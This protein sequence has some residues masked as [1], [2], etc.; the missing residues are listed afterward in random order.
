MDVLDEQ[1]D[2]ARDHLRSEQVNDFLAPGRRHIVSNLVSP[3]LLAETLRGAYPNLP[4][5]VIVPDVSAI[6]GQLS[7]LGLLDP[8]PISSEEAM[9]SLFPAVE[10]A[11]KRIMAS[12]GGPDDTHHLRMNL[13][14]DNPAFQS[15]LEA[16]VGQKCKYHHSL[17]DQSPSLWSPVNSILFMD[18]R[19]IPGD[20]GKSITDAS[21]FLY[22]IELAKK[23]PTMPIVLFS[24]TQQRALQDTVIEAGETD[25]LHNII[26]R[27]S[28]P[29]LSA[30]GGLNARS[31]MKSLKDLADAAVEAVMMNE[32]SR[33]MSSVKEVTLFAPLYSRRWLEVLLSPAEKPRRIASVPVPEVCQDMELIRE[34][35]MRWA[36]HPQMAEG[37]GADVTDKRAGWVWALAVIR[38]WLA[39]GDPKELVKFVGRL[40]AGLLPD[41]G[42]TDSVKGI[43]SIHAGT[44]KDS[45]HDVLLWATGS[46]SVTLP[47]AIKTIMQHICQG[48]A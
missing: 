35:A 43:P 18:M 38:G 46:E 13:V 20:D 34:F 14:D 8:K 21:G 16:V 47:V 3:T 44:G 25:G 1:D 10:S 19:L 4:S 28:K 37:V 31:C 32:Q 27:F 30:H 29:S 11:R 45:S 7:V 26:T 23:H 12:C 40:E 2:T 39:A 6:R 22:A 17:P 24:S 36:N 5:G 42:M 15:I 33:A 9:E 41:Y 48:K